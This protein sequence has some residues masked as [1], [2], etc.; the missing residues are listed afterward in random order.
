MK[1]RVVD[2]R[3]QVPLL[4]IASFGRGGGRVLTPA[5]RQQIALTVSRAPEV[6]IK[7]T[8][9]ARNLAG[10]GRHF[11]YIGRQGTLDVELDTSD[12]VRPK[13]IDK[14]LVEDWDLD[15]EVHAG[16][17]ARSVRAPSKPV[18]LVHNII[19]SMPARTPPDKVL[20]AVR[21]FAT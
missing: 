17:S 15:L 20:R 2:L 11:D 12:Y 1:R 7:V 3:S 13:G 16:P 18:K 19:F 21:A 4:D 5:L 8:G 6:M 14:L 10:V 9:G